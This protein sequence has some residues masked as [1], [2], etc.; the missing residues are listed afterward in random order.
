MK[1]IADSLDINQFLTSLR[2]SLPQGDFDLKA[3]LS[4]LQLL[5]RERGTRHISKG[6]IVHALFKGYSNSLDDNLIDEIIITHGKFH[7]CGL[8]H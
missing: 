8:I 4:E 6:M 7:L 5:V 1:N 3:C 2:V